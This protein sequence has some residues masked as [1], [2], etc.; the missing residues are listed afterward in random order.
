[1]SSNSSRSSSQCSDAVQRVAEHSKT[2]KLLRPFAL[3]DYWVARGAYL[4]KRG[5]ISAATALL[6]EAVGHAHAHDDLEVE[7]W[8]YFHLA[9]CAAHG[10]KPIEAIKLQHRG[11]LLGGDVALFGEYIVDYTNYKLN[12][13][14]GQLSAKESIM[15]A[16]KLLQSRLRDCSR[17]SSLDLKIVLSNILI[18]LCH[19]MEAE[20][21]NVNALGG[22]P[23]AEY[24]Q[25]M[26]AVSEAI[27][28]LQEC[29]GGIDLVNAVMT[30]AMLMYKDPSA[31]GDPRPRLETI[32]GVIREAETEAE[33]LFTAACVGTLN[34]LTI[35]LPTSRMLAAV[36]NAR[37]SCLLEIANADKALEAY[38]REQNRPDFPSFQGMDASAIT[39]FLDDS[40]PKVFGHRLS[41]VEEAVVA[42]SEASNLHKRNDGRVDSLHLL[43]EALFA[44]YDYQTGAKVWIEPPPPPPPP[45]PPL[46]EGE[47]NMESEQDGK[48][49][50]KSD[51]VGGEDAGKST[52]GD[53]IEGTSATTSAGFSATF[54]KDEVMHPQLGSD[55]MKPRAILVLEQAI[56]LGLKTRK[57]DMASRAA[58]TLACV[59]GSANPVDCTA[60]LALAQSCRVADSHLSIF[61][62][63]ADSQDTETLIIKNQRAS[64]EML[65]DTSSSKYSSS[66]FD[67]LQ[68]SCKAWRRLEIKPDRCLSRL[69][70]LPAGLLVFSLQWLVGRGG[71][72]SLAIASLSS[73]TDEV[74]AYMAPAD[75]AQLAAATKLAASYRGA[76]EKAL[77]NESVMVGGR[78]PRTSVGGKPRSSVAA[79]A[80]R[81][82]SVAL[83]GG[84]PIVVP[85]DGSP[86]F[87]SFPVKAGWNEICRAVEMLLAPILP[88]WAS[89]LGSEGA[90]GKKIVL[91][92]DGALSSLPIEAL[93]VLDG[94]DCLS[95]DFSLH[96]LLQRISEASGQAEVAAGDMTYMVDLRHEDIPPPDSEDGAEA[97]MTT[98]PAQFNRLKNDFGTG[99]TGV[100][101]SA[102]GI[103][104]EGECQRMMSGAKALLYYGHGRF[105]SYVAPSAVACID[106]SHCQ[107]TFLASNT[108]SEESERKQAKLDNRKS[109]AQRG[110]EDPYETAA[111]LSMRGVDTVVLPTFP[112][113]SEGNSKLL[114]SVFNANS[115][116]EGG[117]DIAT[118]VW[119]AG[120]PK[121]NIGTS[122]NDEA[123]EGAESSAPVEDDSPQSAPFSQWNY[124]VYGLPTVKLI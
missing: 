97:T 49:E 23:Q 101:G 7:A 29:G 95:R 96:I 40:A 30:K 117:A 19:V 62:S 33:R 111:L 86:L 52:G 45:A 3:R 5:A 103:P 38:D 47:E 82:S 88:A 89:F 78:K 108:I 32:R 28:L 63:A 112:C 27:S 121:P 122:V 102:E 37:A 42:A 61:M 107:V 74:G 83:F 92:V 91:L 48:N 94:A 11:Q 54:N 114:R 85:D 56:E 113:T 4:A 21:R 105:L 65:N 50:E 104:G 98:I 123:G 77:V 79:S 64:E 12:T 13:R 120:T 87:D 60:A 72:T 14:D 110:L 70:D 93:E 68:S 84:H 9:K 44:V 16:I 81:R 71:D 80:P 67:R 8:A 17:G 75:A 18:E 116:V 10:N 1:M 24:A 99:W 55:I 59:H 109:S 2:P 39:A 118:A 53:V 6:Q 106:L 15:R 20:I 31:K 124:I 66:L 35:S 119:S 76:L 22:H 73:N 36:K 100:M 43:G 26:N 90:K 69:P 115:S 57:Y 58:T 41:C 46:P 34:P 51:S 25:A